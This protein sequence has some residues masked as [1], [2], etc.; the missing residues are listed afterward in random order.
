MTDNATRNKC[1]S[2][3]TLPQLNNSNQSYAIVDSFK[4]NSKWAYTPIFVNITLSNCPA[5]NASNTTN[6]TNGTS[7]GTNSTN[8][9]NATFELH[10][11]FTHLK[12]NQDMLKFL[13]N[14]GIPCAT[15]LNKM[16]VTEKT[17]VNQIGHYVRF[18]NSSYKDNQFEDEDDL[19]NNIDVEDRFLTCV[20]KEV[21]TLFQTQNKS[22]YN[23]TCSF[24]INVTNATNSSNAS[25]SSS[26]NSSN[27][28]NV[29][30]CNS[31]F[32]RDVL[33]DLNNCT[34]GTCD[35]ADQII[36]NISGYCAN[37]T[38]IVCLDGRCFGQDFGYHKDDG[39]SS[40]DYDRNQ[41][42]A[43]FKKD[44]RVSLKTGKRI[45][46][47]LEL[48]DIS[49][50]TSFNY[51]P[52]CNDTSSCAVWFCTSFLRGPVAR[53][54]KIYNPQDSND[55]LDNQTL[56]LYAN[57]QDKLLRILQVSTTSSSD[58]VIS[59]TA[60]VDFN[61]VAGQSSF[62][63]NVTID[64]VSTAADPFSNSTNSNNGNGSFGER[65]RVVIGVIFAILLIVI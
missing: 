13:T 43:Q 60:G 18:F 35:S 32:A 20:F 19:K 39:K 48:P 59:D 8:T 34:N 50:L 65:M 29:N 17:I 62:A 33:G 41:G 42:R 6:A 26:S 2:N 15:K 52:P 10:F 24:F 63:T 56:S 5:S 58:T 14:K 46:D 45:P 55:D 61:Q 1:D 36:T 11:L 12:P 64:G 40:M 23:D 54:E 7:N 51:I 25:N 9:T 28:T 3:P 57:Q 4:T 37:K 27:Y 31:S 21:Q 30:V 53:L 44:P 22:M 38:C 16:N 47:F 49:F